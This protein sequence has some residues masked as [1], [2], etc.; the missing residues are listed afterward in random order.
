MGT[1]TGPDVP[2]GVSPQVGQQQLRV[3]H[4]Q[5]RQVLGQALHARVSHLLKIKNVFEEEKHLILVE[6]KIKKRKTCFQLL[7]GKEVCH[8]NNSFLNMFSKSI[9]LCLILVLR[10][11]CAKTAFAK[12]FQA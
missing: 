6:K 10:Q 8:A 5:L 7:E 3:P 9:Q 4:Q 11:K 1:D 2:E 12:H